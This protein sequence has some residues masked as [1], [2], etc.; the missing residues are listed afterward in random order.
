MNAD[1]KATIAERIRMEFE[2]LTRSERVLGNALLNDYPVA[3]LASITELAKTAKVSAPTVVR[4]VQKLGFS[5]YP[6]FQAALRDELAAQF[7]NPITKH[8]QMAA[9]APSEHILNRFSTAAVENLRSSLKLMDHRDF[10]AIADLLADTDR[11]LYFVGGRISH[12]LADYMYTHFHATRPGVFQLSSSASLW[13]QH[14]L[15]MTS[16]D[17]LILFD[18]RRYERNLYDLAKLASSR[19]AKIILFTDQWM[20]PTSKLASHTLPLRIDVPS[21][22]DSHIVLLFVAE[23]LLAGVVERRWPE[24]KSRMSELEA[25]FDTTRRFNKTPEG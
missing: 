7:D 8:D 12:A 5:G 20:S 23:A 19:G 1:Q 6:D 22:W 18:V 17:V 11:Q 24:M 2:Q 4:M 13:P 15:N 16:G 9:D 21:S 25:L 3:G 14:V 10:D